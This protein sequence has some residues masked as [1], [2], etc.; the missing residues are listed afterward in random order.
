MIDGAIHG[1]LSMG[2]VNSADGITRG[3]YVPVAQYKD[4]IAE[5]IGDDSGFVS[6][7]GESGNT[8]APVD[9]DKIVDAEVPAKTPSETDNTTDKEDTNKDTTDTTATTTPTTQPT[10]TDSDRDTD[11]TASEDTDDDGYI[12]EELPL[13][14][15]TVVSDNSS[16][17]GDASATS[18]PSK[19]VEKNADTPQ[20]KT[21]QAHSAS[22]KDKASGPMVKTGGAAESASFFSKIKALF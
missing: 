4:W 2:T 13:T 20:K 7:Q 22:S 10:D 9:E 3:L 21:P 19:T 15:G 17:Q 16:V 6:P 14:P 1:V 18:T 11:S 12:T 5:T 8:D